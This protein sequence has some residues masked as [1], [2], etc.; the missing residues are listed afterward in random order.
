MTSVPKFNNY[1]AVPCSE[2]SVY[3]HG[4]SYQFNF[5]I[6]VVQLEVHDANNARLWV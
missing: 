2:F 6:L 1:L 5:F 4:K 3:Y